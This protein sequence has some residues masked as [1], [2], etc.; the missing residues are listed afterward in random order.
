M[1]FL[2]VSIFFVFLLASST[3]TILKIDFRAPR[4]IVFILME[5]LMLDSE[6]FI[7]ELV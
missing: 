2:I 5:E 3:D 7:Y 1:I 4:T 6:P